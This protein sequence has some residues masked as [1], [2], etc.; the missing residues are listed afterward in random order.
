MPGPMS[1]WNGGT[2]PIDTCMF[3]ASWEA[4]LFT[5][6]LLLPKTKK[7]ICFRCSLMFEV[8]HSQMHRRKRWSIYGIKVALLNLL[9]QHGKKKLL[10]QFVEPYHSDMLVYAPCAC[11]VYQEMHGDLDSHWWEQK[12]AASIVF[13]PHCLVPLSLCLSLSILVWEIC[14]ST[15]QFLR[16][17]WSSVASKANMMPVVW[18]N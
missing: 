6:F 7:K 14:P 17:S 9:D 13:P 10:I 5:I 3:A 16:V 8:S 11:D 1:R 12:V 4:D 15:D 18:S 2:C